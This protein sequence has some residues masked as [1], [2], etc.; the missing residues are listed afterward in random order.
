MFAAAVAYS[1]RYQT[2]I[3][4]YLIELIPKKLSN[5]YISV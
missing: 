4:A 1:L 5:H 3:Q 2:V